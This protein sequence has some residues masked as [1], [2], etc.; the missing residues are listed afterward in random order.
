MTAEKVPPQVL[1]LELP[2]S[3]TYSEQDVS[4]TRQTVTANLDLSGGPRTFESETKS[5]GTYRGFDVKARLSFS[6][7]YDKDQAKLAIRGNDDNTPEQLRITTFLSSGR[8]LAFNQAPSLV[9]QVMPNDIGQN[10]ALRNMWA[11][12]VGQR[13]A[14]LGALSDVARSCN[15]ILTEAAMNAGVSSVLQRGTPPIVTLDNVDGFKRMFGEPMATETTDTI[16]D[17]TRMQSRVTS[18]YVGTVTWVANATFAN[19]IGSTDDPKNAGATTWIGL[20]RDKCNGG[21]DTTKCSSYNFFSVDKTKA[22]ST[23]FV[24]G[25]VIPGT[26]AKTM[27]VGSTVYIFPICDIHNASDSNYMKMLYNPKGVQLNYW[28]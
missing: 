7:E 3:P 15:D 28:K 23:T 5:V 19:V 14:F 4:L 25:H 21:L 13:P 9:F 8:E 20:W 11:A 22:C 1:T 12:H 6:Y 27:A 16:A 17:V 2:L 10:Q 26:T 24:G 18:T